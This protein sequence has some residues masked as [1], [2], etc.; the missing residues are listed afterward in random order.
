[1]NGQQTRDNGMEK[2]DANNK[3]WKERAIQELN[4]M[5]SSRL[6]SGMKPT[7]TTEMIIKDI[8]NLCGQ[9]IPHPNLA[10]SLTMWAI[11]NG[12]IKETGQLTHTTD[13]EKH[14][15]RAMTYVWCPL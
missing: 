11:R 2:V 3:W 1:M 4:W 6:I 9:K 15:R 8:E 12:I 5:R 7:F 10:G 14:S 13:V